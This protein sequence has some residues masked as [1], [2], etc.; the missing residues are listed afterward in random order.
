MGLFTN[1]LGYVGSAAD[2][3]QAYTTPTEARAATLA[4]AEAGTLNN[5]YIS[6]ATLIASETAEFAS[7]PPIGSTTPNTGAFTT[8]SASSGYTGSTTGSAP[9]SGKIGQRIFS[10]VLVGAAVP[11]TNNTAA[12]VTSIVLPVGVWSVK[13]LAAF[14]G[15]GLTGTSISASI[16][17]TSATQGTPGV[18][19]SQTSV[20]P[21]TADVFL[22]I[23]DVPVLVT[24]GTQTVYMVAT[25]LFS[26]G[27]MTGYGTI[28]AFRIA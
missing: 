20:M 11:L 21:T 10:T 28:E 24:S 1:P 15:S 7:P 25:S 16:S 18:N 2:P 17:T 12:N 8:L 22:S 4:E 19:Q 5:V 14:D 27:T 23:P 26:A 3:V 6:P 13:C 9:A